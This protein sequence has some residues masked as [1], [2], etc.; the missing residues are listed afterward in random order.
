VLRNTHKEIGYDPRPSVRFQGDNTSEDAMI[1]VNA[2][3]HLIPVSSQTERLFAYRREELLGQ[4][5]GVVASYVA[6][7]R[8]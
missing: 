4:P 5:K 1:V 2:A 7:P 6:L 3:G 8:L